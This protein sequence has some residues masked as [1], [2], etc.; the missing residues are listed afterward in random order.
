MGAW[1]MG[2]RVG[3]FANDGTV[4]EMRGHSSTLVVMGTFLLWFGWFGFNPGSNLVVASQAAATVVSR[5]AVTTAL[6]G[7]A[8]GISM[9]FYK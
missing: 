9:L 7:G 4:N 6:A 1:I 8:G 3:R 5:V 2:P